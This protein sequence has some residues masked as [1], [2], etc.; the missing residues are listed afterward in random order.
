VC[1]ARFVC[2]LARFK[3]AAFTVPP[4]GSLRLHL[5]N[6][7]HYLEVTICT[8][9]L[10]SRTFPKVTGFG[11]L[12]SRERSSLFAILCRNISFVFLLPLIIVRKVVVNY[13][14]LGTSGALH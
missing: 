2:C 9:V 14:C 4:P 6:C 7:G 5:E 12:L 8:G 11:V 1:A 10:Y 13:S 3:Y